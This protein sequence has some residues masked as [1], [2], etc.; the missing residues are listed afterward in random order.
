MGPQITWDTAVSIGVTLFMSASGGFVRSLS[1]DGP[2]NRMRSLKST[3]G[4]VIT[5]MFAGLMLFCI[6]VECEV[7]FGYRATIAGCA[8]YSSKEV[9]KFLSN[10]LLKRL[11][12]LIK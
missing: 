8:G 5:A 3:M 7:P 1:Q 9:L 4:E 6:L 11:E 12:K 2:K 10:V